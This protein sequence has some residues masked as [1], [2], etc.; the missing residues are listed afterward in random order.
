[1]ERPRL[2][3]T[4]LPVLTK[5]YCIT[6]AIGLFSGLSDLISTFNASGS[7]MGTTVEWV[8]WVQISTSIAVLITGTWILI[9]ILNRRWRFLYVLYAFICIRIF[10]IIVAFTLDANFGYQALGSTLVPVAWAIYF[11]KSVKLRLAFPIR[12]GVSA[13]PAPESSEIEDEAYNEQ[14]NIED[15]SVMNDASEA[16]QA[17]QEQPLSENIQSRI[18]SAYEPEQ[19]QSVK[20]LF[21]KNCGTECGPN[22][23][24]CPNC[25]KRV[26]YIPAKINYKILCIAFLLLSVGLCIALIVQSQQHNAEILDLKTEMKNVVYEPIPANDRSA[27]PTLYAKWHVACI[28]ETGDRYHEPGC[29]SLSRSNAIYI[30]SV[31]G[32]ERLGYTPCSQCHEPSAIRYIEENQKNATKSNPII[33]GGV[34]YDGVSPYGSVFVVPESICYHQYSCVTIQ[35]DIDEV[36]YFEDENSAITAGYRACPQCIK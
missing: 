20:K 29:G 26:R 11:N 31:S 1:M 32:A 16:V 7:F 14:E 19:Q 4:P 23:T 30:V 27:T 25:G 35:N 10:Y 9:D 15:D 2:N 6:L 8:L 34:I 13:L 24:K 33:A 3:E 28:T 5:I 21:C 18:D 12:G 17:D 36:Y 22:D